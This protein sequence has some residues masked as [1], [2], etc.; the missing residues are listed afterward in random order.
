MPSSTDFSTSGALK[1]SISAIVFR[2]RLGSLAMGTS[3]TASMR[4][5]RS[6]GDGDQRVEA[7]RDQ[8]RHA[9]DDLER[10]L[11]RESSARISAESSGSRWAT[12]SAA[13]A[14]DSSRQGAGDVAGRGALDRQE[15]ALLEQVLLDLLEDRGGLRPCRASAGASRRARPRCARA[16]RRAGSGCAGSSFCRRSMLAGSTWR[17]SIEPIASTTL[18][19]TCSSRCLMISAACSD[20]RLSRKAATR[21]RRRSVPWRLI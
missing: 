1:V 18:T 15:R 5:F 17:L 7:R 9:L 20:S 21:G 10:T 6:V 4:A 3:A 19:M 14:G 16:R 11:G 12:T 2:R 8:V 13:T